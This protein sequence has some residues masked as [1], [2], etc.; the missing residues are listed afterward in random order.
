[1]TPMRTKEALLERE[2]KKE[3]GRGKASGK[4]EIRGGIRK[5][6]AREEAKEKRK[7]EHSKTVWRGMTCA[8]ADT[9]II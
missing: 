9:I 7:R 3:R 6:S 4:T 8:L 1:M 2:D 5:K